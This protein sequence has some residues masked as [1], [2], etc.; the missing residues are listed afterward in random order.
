[1]QAERGTR[2]GRTPLR[3]LP[4]DARLRPSVES[5]WSSYAVCLHTFR[6]S[7]FDLAPVSVFDPDHIVQFRGT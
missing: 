2:F 1:M 3:P 5:V 7:I 4:K 6:I